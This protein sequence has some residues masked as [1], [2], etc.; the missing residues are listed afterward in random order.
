MEK[1]TAYRAEDG[2]LHTTRASAG[3]ADLME[4]ARQRQTT[5]S[6]PQLDHR[7]I[8]FIVAHRIKIKEILEAI[9]ADQAR[10]P[11]KSLA[12]MSVRAS[13]VPGDGKDY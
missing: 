8:S 1:T 2:T 10:V 12:A 9:D 13:D 6:G 11:P 5:A 3:A 4:F 7:S